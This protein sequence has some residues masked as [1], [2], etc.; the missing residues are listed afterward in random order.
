MAQSDVLGRKK[1]EG[2]CH[3][4]DCPT[5]VDKGRSLS[6]SEVMDGGKVE[7]QKEGRMT[8][9]V[10]GT[11]EKCSSHLERQEKKNLKTE[12]CDGGL[13]S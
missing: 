7:Q 5:R 9:R 8:E 10:N 12:R 4:Q 1:T 2:I 3:P 11:L 13:K 6:R